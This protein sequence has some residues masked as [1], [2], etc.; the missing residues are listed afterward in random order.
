MHEAP[1][2]AALH[3][4]S[5]HVIQL[6]SYS[7]SP[8]WKCPI[9]A[10]VFTFAYV[11]VSDIPSLAT[12]TI[13]KVKAWDEFDP[14]DPGVARSVYAKWFFDTPSINCMHGSPILVDARTIHR[15]T[16]ASTAVQPP[17]VQVR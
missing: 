16:R 11:P 12:N 10:P 15:A 3:M 8:E 14:Q 2:T 1:R 6:N 7:S 5:M 9:A 13:R 17:F 4:R